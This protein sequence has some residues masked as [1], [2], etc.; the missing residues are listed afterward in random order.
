MNSAAR[1]QGE[2]LPGTLY[3]S[4][5]SW[6]LVSDDCHRHS[7]GFREI[8]GKGKGKGKQELFKIEGLKT[9]R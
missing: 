6:D 7:L 4:A 5:T 2:T 3:V 8:K 1:L 9:D